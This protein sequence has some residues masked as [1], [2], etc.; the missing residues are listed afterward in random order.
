MTPARDLD[1]VPPEDAVVV[2]VPAGGADAPGVALVIEALCDSPKRLCVVLLALRPEEAPSLAAR[3]ARA[4]VHRAGPTV[5]LARL[6]ARSV[7]CVDIAPPARRSGLVARA[8]RRGLPVFALSRATAA[9]LENGEVA[10]PLSALSSSASEALPE[11]GD[12]AQIA[13]HLIKAM[14][15]ER[16]DGPMLGAAS[17]LAQRLMRGPGH[18]VLAPLAT[19]IANRASLAQELGQPQVIMCLGNGPTSADP[20]LAGMAHDALFRVNHQWMQDGYMTDAD[21]LFAGVK[22]SMRAAGSTPIAVASRRKEEALLGARL[23]T[24]W[25]GRFRY[26]VVEEIADLGTALHGHPRPTTGAVMLAAAIALAPRRLIVAG[27]DMFADKAGA[28]PGRAQAVN[29]YTAAHD[30]QTDETFIRAHLAR[31]KG[32]IMTLSPAFSELAHSVA[33]SQFTLADPP[34]A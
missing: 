9:A 19:R 1:I 31:F 32:E 4:F 18:V 27:M 33:D 34:Q 22:R 14:G 21:L 20:R 26:V 16:G 11:Q 3:F 23:L 15:F 7:L 29:A 12:G 25:R 2:V 10:D 17:R 13:D 8:I 5:L 30:R 28:Y 24:P 6:R